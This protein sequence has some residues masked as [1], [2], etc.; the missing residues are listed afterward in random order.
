MKADS[1][2]SLQTSGAVLSN[3]AILRHMKLGNVVITPFKKSHL[4]T[5]SYDLTLGEYYFEP[6]HPKFA[7]NIYNPFSQTEVRRIWGKAQKA[8][9]AK[10]V[11]NSV[12]PKMLLGARPNDRVILIPPG[13]V[14][15]CHTNEYIG[16]RN[17]VTT[18]MKARSSM[19][20]NFIEVCRDAGWGDV[21]YI[22]RWTMEIA[23]TSDEY[24]ISLVVGRR[25]AQMIFFEVELPLKE[26]DDYSSTGKYQTHWD[27]K[28]LKKRWK[29]EDMLPKLYKD[30]DEDF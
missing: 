5:S 26:D 20:R 21:G 9:L 1:N 28:E 4:K 27:L 10:D 22:N 8:P 16:G 12:D 24:W 29:P 11:A 25:V 2:T 14:L 19:G 23:N 13:K 17:C 15:L 18:M 7:L 3:T 6:Q 30:L